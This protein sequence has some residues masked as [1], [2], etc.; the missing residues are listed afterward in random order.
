MEIFLQD[1]ESFYNYNN[2]LDI[3]NYLS[4]FFKLKHNKPNIIFIVKTFI[5]NII[6]F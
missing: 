3:Q 4:N 5:I 2:N 1:L 6:Q